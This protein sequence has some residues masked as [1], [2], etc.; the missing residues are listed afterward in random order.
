MQAAEFDWDE[1]NIEHLAPHAVDTDE[2]EAVLDNNPR[3]LRTRDGKYLAYG[4][5][6]EGRYLLVVFVRKSNQL[7]RVITARDMTPNEK[8]HNRRQK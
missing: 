5:T 3:I 1:M 2:A 7:I 8:R 6:D 4:Q